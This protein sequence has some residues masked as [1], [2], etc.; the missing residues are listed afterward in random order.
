MIALIGLS[1]R[2]RGS[3]EM[4]ASDAVNSWTVWDGTWHIAVAGVVTGLVLG[5][6][7]LVFGLGESPVPQI[8]NGTLKGWSGTAVVVAGCATGYPVGHHL[9]VPALLITLLIASGVGRCGVCGE[10]VWRWRRT[11]SAPG[12]ITVV[13]CRGLLLGVCAASVVTVTVA[14][15]LFDCLFPLSS[16]VEKLLNS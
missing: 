15:S 10:R 7:L 11:V 1:E 4:S 14:V 2:M 8:D 5:F 16:L 3:N 12:S 6:A 9:G 13:S